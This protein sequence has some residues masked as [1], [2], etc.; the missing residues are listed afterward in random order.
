M[1]NYYGIPGGAASGIADAKMPNAQAGWEQATSN[2]MVG[3]SGLNMVYESVGMHASLLGFSLEG[4]ILGDDMLG[5]ALRYVRGIEVNE[6]TLAFDTMSK[7]CLKGP[8]H[9]LGHDQTLDLMQKEYVYPKLADRSSPKEW[10]ELG[11]PDLID[12][13]IARK[14]EILSMPS[15]VGFDFEIEQTIRQKFNIHLNA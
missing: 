1:H 4:L 11:K 3:L 2:V 12:K 5:Q 14:K 8:G 7:V 15:Q 10:E 9:Y 13:A 6:D